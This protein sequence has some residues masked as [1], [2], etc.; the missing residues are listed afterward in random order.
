MISALNVLL[1]SMFPQEVYFTCEV[2]EWSANIS[3]TMD[4][5]KTVMVCD[6]QWN[7]AGLNHLIMSH[8]FHQSLL[9][10]Q[11][12]L[13]TLPRSFQQYFH[14]TVKYMTQFLSTLKES[15]SLRERPRLFKLSTWGHSH[16]LPCLLYVWQSNQ[17]SIQTFVFCL[18]APIFP[19]H[20]Q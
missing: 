10:G 14:D 11:I 12:V 18:S 15:G 8:P 19:L 2:C 17:I 1:Q 3:T 20:H 16:S 7:L 4:R 5:I 6:V 9:Q 13:F